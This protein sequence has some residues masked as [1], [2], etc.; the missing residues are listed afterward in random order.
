MPTETADRS[1]L[2]LHLLRLH[3]RPRGGRSRR[4]DPAGHPLRRDPRR[5]VLPRLRRPQGR[6]RA[7]RGVAGRRSS[8]EARGARRRG[9][10]ARASRAGAVPSQ[11][12]EDRQRQ[13]T[14]APTSSPRG[15]REDLAGVVDGVADASS[16]RR[17]VAAQARSASIVTLDGDQVDA[18]CAP[19]IVPVRRRAA[20]RRSQAAAE[21]LLLGRPY[22]VGELAQQA[23]ARP[24]SAA[25]RF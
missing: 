20:P 16:R 25:I 9:L 1:A 3:L 15:D 14:A 6:L 7:P 2:D 4:R 21:A 19:Q 24:S 17:P 18:L 23:L 5:L 12:A 8:R 13:S 10:T 22:R 11:R